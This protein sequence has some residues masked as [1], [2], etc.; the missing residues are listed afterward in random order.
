MTGI[1]PSR[2]LNSVAVGAQ[3][4][5]AYS[6]YTEL[7]TERQHVNLAADSADALHTTDDA[8]RNA[9]LALGYARDVG[10]ASN[11]L[12]SQIVRP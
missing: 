2:D 4:A 5:I 6:R 8:G 3:M 1:S 11:Q 12:I 10:N 9:L 7:C